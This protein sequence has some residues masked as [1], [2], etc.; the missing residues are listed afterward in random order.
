MTLKRYLIFPQAKRKRM[1]SEFPT[2]K[3]KENDILPDMNIGIVGHVDHGKTSLTEMLTGKWT[4]MHSEEL[5]RGITIRLGYADAIF[6]QCPKCGAYYPTDKCIKCMGECE[7]V[8]AISVIDAPG[9]ETLMA[10]VLSG[11]SLMDAAILVIA[12]NEKVPQPQ[13]AEHLKALDITG[14]ENIII[15][16]NKIDLVTEKE[17]LE[18]Y[19]K[20]KE[21]TKGTV[22]EKAP[23]IPI[24]ARHN[25]NI[26]VLIKTMMEQFKPLKHDS[27]AL[28]KFLIARSFD[29]NKPGTPVA[30]LQG[31]IIGGSLLRGSLKIGD[32]IEI[33]P[34]DMSHGHWSSLK[35]KILSVNQGRTSFKEVKT[36]GLVAIGTGL[37]PSLT[38]GDGLV[39]RVVVKA[40]QKVDLQTK[41]N[42]K[43]ALFDHVIGV[44]E[45]TKVENLQKSDVLLLTAVAA[46]TIGT[47]QKIKSGKAS[48]ELKI[49]LV[50]EKGDKIAISKQVGGRWHLVGYGVLE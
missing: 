31:G 19:K 50:V 47:I 24:S 5:K 3:S 8:R 11:A 44:K 17:A 36:G 34:V 30:K 9:H 28:S 39:G 43:I 10:T 2:K 1:V 18:N 38:K 23:V 40:G 13:T 42:I 21:F 20:I 27:Q 29:I 41:I 4:A 14:I 37:D 32:E 6:Y 12:A 48:L 15:V 46:K 45:N 22:A 35:T 26:D 49:P 16:Q 7:P 25:T 33:Y